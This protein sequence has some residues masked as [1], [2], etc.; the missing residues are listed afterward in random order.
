MNPTREISA[1]P[2][3]RSWRNIRQ[4]VKPLAMGRQG[5]RRQIFAWVKVVALCVL[6]AGAAWGLFEV[7]HAWETDRAA[8]ATA[9][10]SQ[11]VKDIVLITPGG[12]L[13]REWAAG[14]LALPKSASLMSL[15][16]PALRDR[17]LAHGQVRVVVLTRN[18]PATL[19]VTLQERTPVARV[20]ASDG[21]GVPQQL[22]VA[23]DGV[24]YD[25]FNYDRQ[26]VAGLPWLDGIRLV[27]A[28]H[29]FEPI[30]GMADVSALLATARNEAPNLYSGWLIV[31]LARLAENDEI[32]V[33][34]QDIP[35]IIF[36]R[37][38]DYL[39][40][41]AQLDYVVERVRTLPDPTLQSV[42]LALEGGQVPVKLLSTPEEL[43]K[44][45][46]PVLSIPPPQRI[47][48]RDL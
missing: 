28:G 46:A 39:R 32:V 4:E 38:R 13:T 18:F 6:G 22:L 14:V 27:R 34:A 3:G 42:N 10:H 25:G 2:P 43:A 47:V 33:K 23:K 19:V 7:I 17:L 31:S 35:E 5:R 15:D 41:V 12:V 36:S 30:A 11:P 44:M 20:Q 37:K 40:Q 29:G 21:Q 45:P 8:L 1:P 16:L 26:M 48:K 9:V 24:V